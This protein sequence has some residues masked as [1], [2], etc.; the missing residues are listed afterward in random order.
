MA[1]V[2]SC[3][4]YQ[5]LKNTFFYWTPPGECL[6]KWMK[7]MNYLNG[8]IWDLI[9]AWFSESTA[10]KMKFSIEDFRPNP[11]FPVIWSHLLSEAWME[12]IIFC[13]VKFLWALRLIF[14]PYRNQLNDFHCKSK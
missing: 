4:F 10:E 14:P 9:I 3:E 12:K 2:F 6:L 5:I 8:F 13:A 1:Q 7:K 11:Q